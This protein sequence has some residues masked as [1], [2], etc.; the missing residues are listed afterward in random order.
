MKTFGSLTKRG[1]EV[2]ILVKSE[3][4]MYR[5]F[6]YQLLI[7]LKQ[8]SHDFRLGFPGGKPVELQY[9]VV[10]I[11]MRFEQLS[12]KRPATAL[13][14]ALWTDNVS[15]P[16]WYSVALGIIFTRLLESTSG[17]KKPIGI[18]ALRSEDTS[19][20]TIYSAR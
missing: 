7:L 12:S 11:L 8:H 18:Y 10:Q 2:D 16:K 4:L 19:G 17:G 6:L 14:Q 15:M 9:S 20:T 3:P 5:L 13:I 1:S